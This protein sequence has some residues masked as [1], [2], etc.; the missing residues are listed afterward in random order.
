[1]KFMN[2]CL[3]SLFVLIAFCYIAFETIGQ[4]TVT[5]SDGVVILSNGWFSCSTSDQPLKFY[6]SG[7]KD[8]S[9]KNNEKC[10][11]TF[12]PGDA[13]K[14]VRITLSNISIFNNPSSIPFGNNDVIKIYSGKEEKTE[15]LLSTIIAQ[16]SA[17]VMSTSDD[18][19]ITIVFISKNGRVGTGFE[20]VA[21][22]ETPSDMQIDDV[23]LYRDSKKEINIVYASQKDVPVIGINIHALNTSNPKKLSKIVFDCSEGTALIA[24]ATLY[25]S[26]D[27]AFSKSKKL[28]YVEGI[29]SSEGNILTLDDKFELSQ[30][31]NYLWLAFDIDKKSVN[32]QKVSVNIQ[33]LVF[34]SDEKELSAIKTPI[35]IKVNNKWISTEGVNNIYVSQ[36]WQ[37]VASA[38]SYYNTMTTGDQIVTFHPSDNDKAIQLDFSMF[39]IY[40][41]KNNYSP[42]PKFIVVSGSDPK[43]R[44]VL[45]Q[46]N[47]ENNRTIPQRIRSKSS[48]GTV[49]VVWNHNGSR[50]DK[51]WDAQVSQY[52]SEQMKF[53]S[54]EVSQPGIGNVSMSPSP[55]NLT[56][57]LLKILTTGDKKNLELKNLKLKLK[58][59]ESISKLYIY[60]KIDENLT[61]D[62]S[63]AIAVADVNDNAIVTMEIPRS[64][65]LSEGENNLKISCDVKDAPKDKAIDMA[66]LSI[67]IDDKEIQ[68]TENNDPIGEFSFINAVNMPQG[69]ET[70]IINVNENAVVF[71]DNGGPDEKSSEQKTESVITFKPTT[72]GKVIKAIVKSFDV[73]YNENFDMYYGENTET[74]NLAFDKKNIEAGVEYV[75]TSQDG[76]ITFK[77]SNKSKYTKAGWEIQ[78]IEYVPQPI[79]IA[80]VDVENISTEKTF[81]G[82]TSLM[83]RLA[84]KVTG[85]KGQQ[86]LSSVSFDT[87]GSFANIDKAVLYDTE[88]SDIFNRDIIF[89]K[90]DRIKSDAF[91]I[92]GQKIYNSAGV[93]YLFLEYSI[94]EKSKLES[95][96][97]AQAKD[98]TISENSS[99]L[100]VSNDVVAKTSV[101]KGF[102]GSYIIGSSTKAHY[103]T[104]EDAINAM[105]IGVDGKVD[106]AIEDGKY[107]GSIL[108]KHINGTSETNTVTFR[109]LSSS[110]S[111]VC[112]F[113]NKY[114][115]P[116]YSNNKSF[117]ERGVITLDSLQYFTLK[118]VT[119]KTEDENYPMVIKMRSSCRDITFDN[120]VVEAP[121]KT[122]YTDGY[123]I[124]TYVGMG[125]TDNMPTRN[126][127]L[128]NCKLIGG[129]IG[130]SF[131]S[132]WISKGHEKGI[133]IVNSTFE[134]QGGKAIYISGAE[135]LV[136]RGNNIS[137]G[138]G[139]KLYSLDIMDITS[140]ENVVI[141]GNYINMFSEST[142]SNSVFYLRDIK[143][144]EQKPL[145]IVNNQ[146][147]I[148]AK[149]GSNA[150]VFS[151][152]ARGE[153]I[154]NM[155]L[156]FNTI[157]TK[158][159]DDNATIL[160]YQTSRGKFVNGII[161]NNIFQT[162]KGTIHKLGDVIEGIEFSNNVSFASGNTYSSKKGIKTGFEEWQKSAWVKSETNKNVEFISEKILMPKSD[163]Q[164]NIV[165]DKY[166]IDYDIIGNSRNE[167]N[168]VGAY[169]YSDNMQRLNMIDGYPKIVSVSNNSV[170]LNMKFDNPGLVKVITKAK[171]EQAP[172]MSDFDNADY[173]FDVRKNMEFEARIDNLA[174][175]TKYTVYILAYNM[176]GEQNAEIYKMDVETETDPTIP[177][178][179][180]SEQTDDNGNVV[181]GTFRFT[182]ISVVDTQGKG[183]VATSGKMAE[184]TNSTITFTN[185]ET[186]QNLNGFF[187]NSK[188]NATLVLTLV[189]DDGVE[190][191]ETLVADD[192]DSQWAYFNLRNRG[193][194]K[195]IV[196]KAGD[197]LFI[198]DFNSDPLPFSFEVKDKDA[199]LGDR[200][201][202]SVEKELKNG[203][204][205][206]SYKWTKIGQMET[207]VSGDK[208]NIT[209]ERLMHYLIEGVDAWGRKH[210][211][212][213]WIKVKSPLTVATFEDYNITDNAHH[214]IGDLTQIEDVNTGVTTQW[215]SG[216]FRFGTTA[217]MSTWWS[218]YALSRETEKDFNGLNDQFRVPTGA[219]VDD[220]RG[221]MVAYPMYDNV[222]KIE[223]TSDADGD[224]VKGVFINNASYTV[225]SITKGD[226]FSSAFG[227]N[228]YFKVVFK[229]VNASGETKT[230]DYYLADFRDNDSKEHYYTDSWQW[231]DLS[232]LGKIKYIS[233]GFDSN[234]KNQYGITVPAYVC[235]DN[236][237]DTYHTENIRT[238]KVVLGKNEIKLKEFVNFNE[239]DA[240][241]KYEIQKYPDDEN[242]K[243]SVSQEGILNID[244]QRELSKD[245]EDVVIKITQKGKSVYQLHPVSLTSGTYIDE[246]GSGESVSVYPVPAD[247]TLNISCVNKMYSVE[248]FT[249]DGIMVRRNKNLTGKNSI[250]VSSLTSGNYIVKINSDGETFVKKIVVKH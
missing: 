156:I 236:L 155:K 121:Q 224:I 15:N 198:D 161:A 48:D 165:A 98:M 202:W 57:G 238:H 13:S 185:R 106:F 183:Y 190:R 49:T 241:I 73:G 107:D 141:D 194:I 43:G 244:V 21:T 62:P 29:G 4:T 138:Q 63:K 27:N 145:V 96:V 88:K 230:V 227:N 166:G 225:N 186:P 235:L 163:D 18:G 217:H 3:R 180:E 129:R 218:G 67:N 133:E 91:E 131:G 56:F 68:L 196:M 97:I 1:M 41:D 23:S 144:T 70:K 90:T 99:K 114:M 10:V 72:P 197:K 125:K 205:P 74:A 64:I 182:N 54:A 126:I 150:T 38:G 110:P 245:V 25:S 20:G 66:V 51:G 75:S 2:R 151:F 6:D 181:S 173:S 105:D 81:K 78:I 8:G 89:G 164:L 79:K 226:S 243:V 84:V 136:I 52:K 134:N 174:R 115:A 135:N 120:V 204:A 210:T 158:G 85:D 159:D 246:K 162:N 108:F 169:V 234:K 94:S 80:S 229:G 175:A 50:A 71:Y 146:V 104:I 152:N 216:S 222:N 77:Y 242:I 16:K 143:A 223:I 214:F 122:S 147:Y 231:V 58:G 33:K 191:Q 35:D 12:I 189:G 199:N 149:K 17:N 209:A 176:I 160:N 102:S 95:P 239:S 82:S 172:Q 170:S 250:D 130:V 9:Y 28:G 30:G 123:L 132:T 215:Y 101:G 148:D 93:Y 195:N 103:K 153:G 188:G 127:S 31:D 59:Y 40:W 213:A 193:S 11:F 86:T 211:Q 203:V 247:N 119:V 228:D 233:F 47:G 116:G 44:D 109:S 14:K 87:K 37:F 60:D 53:V 208:I 248:V 154:K 219:G 22:Q 26:S 112:I 232:P 7:G 171:T 92:Y 100:S 177:A 5:P 249:T 111:S 220:S 55:K 200:V 187:Y 39:S 83:L 76:A 178:T 36:P 179:F 184:V 113:H 34:E 167:S 45:F 65:Y 61:S 46:L 142:R 192:T 212:T 137:S 24:N 221:F 207:P 206:Y 128:K 42:N 157:K 69:G 124:M 237:G 139:V 118:G 32:E 201:A 240:K 168:I 140:G 117:E 19:A